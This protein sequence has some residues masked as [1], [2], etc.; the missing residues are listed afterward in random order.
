[1]NNDST[2]ADAKRGFTFWIADWQKDRALHSCSPEARYAWFEIL[3]MCFESPQR[4]FLLNPN[5]NPYTIPQLARLIGYSTQRMKRYLQ[6]LGV[7]GVY[8]TT[9]EGVIYNRKMAREN[10][11]LNANRRNA[12]LGGRKPKGEPNQEPKAIPST[13]KPPLSVSGSDSGS[14]STIKPIGSSEYPDWFENC[15]SARPFRHPSG[16]DPKRPA[17]EAACARIKEGLETEES[18]L[19]I[20]ENWC[21]AATRDGI[22]GT[23]SVMQLKRFY[24]PNEPEF[25]DKFR[26]GMPKGEESSDE[27]MPY[28]DPPAKPKG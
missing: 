8:S 13:P 6:E 20:T 5:W 22:A 21:K 9:S 16:S 24:G 28:H 26:K 3:L 15:W 19:V 14:N 25:R 23:K 18:L 27:R 4:G 1:M 7:A 2:K 10:K 11:Q 17:H 12:K